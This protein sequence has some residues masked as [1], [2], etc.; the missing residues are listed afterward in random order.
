MGN[1]IQ[2]PTK[3]SSKDYGSNVNYAAN[4]KVFYIS[5]SND[6]TKIVHIENGDYNYATK[7]SEEVVIK[8][9]NQISAQ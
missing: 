3:Q 7:R 5:G 9:Q 8:Y 4:G 6:E 1:S 2:K